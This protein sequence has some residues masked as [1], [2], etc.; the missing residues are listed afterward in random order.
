[1]LKWVMRAVITLSIVSMVKLI[2]DHWLM[3]SLSHITISDV[4]GILLRSASLYGMII[5]AAL[6][7]LESA[8]SATSNI[9]FIFFS[10]DGEFNSS[11]AGSVAVFNVP[12][13]FDP[14]V[15]LMVRFV[16][17]AEICNV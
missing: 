6:S 16:V 13:V 2:G 12:P 15:R 9:A 7:D 14:S 3:E 5:S 8:E 1:M 10:F 17:S 4:S 11:F